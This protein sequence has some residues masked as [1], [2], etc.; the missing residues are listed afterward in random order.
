MLSLAARSSSAHMVSTRACG[1]FG[2][3]QARAGPMLLRIA[4]CSLCWLGMLKQVWNRRHAAAAR[5]SCAPG[6]RLPCDQRAVL[7][8]ANLHARISGRA[9]TGDLEFRIALQHHAHR[10]AAGF[11]GKLARSRCPSGQGRTCCRIHRPCG[12]DE[13]ECSAAG[14]FSGS[15]IC[16]AIPETF[17]VDMCT[18]RWSSSVHSEVEPCDS[19]QQ[20]VITGAP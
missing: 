13:R 10:L 18:K 11:L 7:F 5:T 9:S 15:A 2:A 12:P 19:M 16:P 4:V 1:W 6:L 17:C 20:C 14:I 3:R 8:R